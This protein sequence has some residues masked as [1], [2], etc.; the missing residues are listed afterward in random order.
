MKKVIFLL[1]DGARFDILDQ[2]IESNSM[3][4]LSSIINKG[5]Y[6]KAVSVFPSTTG[7][8]YI[9]FLMGQY[10]GNAN[11]PGIRWLDKINFSK[12]P[13]SSNAHRSYV[14][15]E[16]KFF[17]ADIKKSF[18]SI[19]NYLPNSV[20]IFNEITSGLN[21]ENDLTLKSKVFYKLLSHFFGSSTIDKI[22]FKKLINSFDNKKQFYFCCLY[23]IDSL[24]HIQGSDT[25]N[26]KQLYKLFDENL[27]E[28]KNF[29]EDKSIYDDT[30]IIIT[31]DHGHSNTQKHFDLVDYLKSKNKS[32]FYYPLI[33]KKLYKKFDSCV[34]VSGNS[35][36][37]IYLNND[38]NWSKP[39]SFSQH[40]ELINDLI[41]QDSVDI[42]SYKNSKGDIIVLS[43]R[44]KSLIS[45]KESSIYY[46][47]LEN[48]PFDYSIGEGFYDENQLLNLT[49][50]TNYPDAIVQ[51]LQIFR[52]N[53]CGD[54]VLSANPGWDFRKKFEFPLH[55]SSHGSLRREHII[56]PLIL[57]KKIDN[58]PKI[59]TVDIYN[60][61]LEF[62]GIKSLNVIE[63][64][65]LD[66]Y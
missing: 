16:N 38:L 47:P 8:A 33:Y 63:G 12:N 65:K 14:G 7:P 57:N 45:D 13:F 23:G 4:N 15:Y 28:L 35:M 44:G 60:T 29:L 24:S 58:V 37:H 22:A 21:K 50:E 31:S 19:F 66:I 64:K 39:F 55:R 40:E 1:L 52:S 25:E 53:R 17:N 3:P 32:V 48:D 20:S 54:L 43:S 46:Q 34:M 2:L 11:M 5:S 30:L 61:M 56:V 9:P 42:L 49:Y 36:A 6:N 10:P 62:L 27:G 51:L 18:K 59:R 41:S 26:I